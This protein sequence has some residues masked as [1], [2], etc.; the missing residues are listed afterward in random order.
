MNTIIMAFSSLQ[1]AFDNLGFLYVSTLRLFQ[2]G[3]IHVADRQPRTATR[4]HWQALQGRLQTPRH[5]RYDLRGA[6]RG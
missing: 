1:T 5:R 3:D 4:A 6:G 2:R